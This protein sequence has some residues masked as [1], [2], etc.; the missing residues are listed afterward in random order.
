MANRDLDFSPTVT[1]DVE[2]APENGLVTGIVGLAAKIADTNE[3]SKLL[4]N[5]TKLHAGYKQL[6][7]QFRM[8]YAGDPNNKE[9]LAKLG[10]DRQTLAESLGGDIG[11]FYQRQW[12]EKTAELATQ[13]DISNDVWTVNQNHVNTVA[14]FNTSVKGY[15]DM[16]NKDG[17]AYGISGATDGGNIMN[18][19][20][21]RNNL[22]QFGN[23]NLGVPKT[24]EMLKVFN[25]DYVKSFV[26]GTAEHSPERAAELLN[27]PKISENFT[28]EDR[29]DMIAQINKVKKQQELG[30]SLQLTSNNSALPDIVNDPNLSYYEKRSQIDKMDMEGSVTPKAAASAR[31]VIKSSDDLDSQTDTPIMADT[32][33]KIYDL[34][35]NASASGSDYLLGVQNIQESI[36]DN[37]SA[38]KL[39]A[40]D[41]GKLN[42]Q[43]DTL[44]SKRIGD[45]T[46]EVGGN[47]YK[48]NQEFNKL[49]PEFRG[50]ATRQLFYKSYGQNYTPDQYITQAQ[51]IIDGVNN[52]RRTKA[53]QIA[54]MTAQNDK[55]F[56]K[57]IK[58]TPQDV[59]DT[60]RKYHISENEVMRRLRQKASQGVGSRAPTINTVA[61]DDSGDEGSV[62]IP[63]KPNT[64]E[65]PDTQSDGGAE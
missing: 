28:T 19:L 27:D 36:L 33:N 65:E 52:D 5:S 15:T 49:P 45:A 24:E 1:T 11:P 55:V 10:E 41:A 44:T 21:A 16:A 9:G 22:E 59:T 39:T 4:I 38:G 14:N 32:I 57:S 46:R 47:F 40:Q 54:T 18:F 42:K 25:S 30:K 64:D 61:P 31:R 20:T 37:Q 17:Q 51:T 48:A 7:A 2:A 35:A 50:A 62:A 12:G 13:S 23:K 58:A 3:Q 29:G 8:D 60:A 26:S 34:N 56:L 63:Q 6:D 53:T 43:M